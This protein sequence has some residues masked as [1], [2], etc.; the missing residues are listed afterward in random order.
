M[1][2]NSKHDLGKVL[3]L[4]LGRQQCLLNCTPG[5]SSKLAFWRRESQHN[6]VSKKLDDL[7]TKLELRLSR[8]EAALRKEDY[9]IPETV[10]KVANQ[11]E[12]PSEA[13][14][15]IVSEA[16][17]EPQ[18]SLKV[19]EGA[20]QALKL[21]CTENKELEKVEQKRLDEEENQFWEEIIKVYLMPE[22]KKTEQ[23][24]KDVQQK[25]LELRNQMVFSFLMINSIWIVTMFL[26][27]QYKDVLGIKWGLTA[28]VISIDWNP[29]D[30]GGDSIIG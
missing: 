6:E 18:G 16:R 30:Q 19:P 11:E 7:D 21:K 2:Q 13:K 20:K 9:D 1:S 22:K 14:Q 29:D 15:K 28:E 25:L 26:M 24:A 12:K 4:I 3:G 23:E 8:L 17:K 5:Y 27:Q 10:K